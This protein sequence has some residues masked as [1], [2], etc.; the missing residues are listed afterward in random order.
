MSELGMRPV[1]GMGLESLTHCRMFL[2]G[3]DLGN[4]IPAVTTEFELPSPLH[5]LSKASEGN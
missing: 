4:V 2:P 1:P 3:L 5:R